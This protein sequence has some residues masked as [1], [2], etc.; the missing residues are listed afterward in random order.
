MPSDFSAATDLESL[1]AN[2]VAEGLRLEFKEKEDSSSAA[3]SRSDKK[4]IAEAVSSF[5]NSDGGTIVFGIKTKRSGDSDVAA[6]LN[7][8]Q[9][10][11]PLLLRIIPPAI[12]HSSQINSSIS[13]TPP[14]PERGQATE[15]AFG[16]KPSYRHGLNP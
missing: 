13:T 5:A 8:P 15:R 12:P 9:P 10:L 2:A 7:P 4:Q 1:C 16:D 11:R 14:Y 6:E 3:V